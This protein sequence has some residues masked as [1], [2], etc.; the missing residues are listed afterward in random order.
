RS[1]QRHPRFPC[2]RTAVLGRRTTFSHPSSAA[3]GSNSSPTL[4]DSF[5]ADVD[6]IK[7]GTMTSRRAFV[8]CTCFVVA[9]A[10]VVLGHLTLVAQGSETWV[11]TWKLNV[12]KSKYSPGPGPK[13]GTIKISA[14][15]GGWAAVSDA[16]G[17]DGKPTHLEVN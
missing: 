10:V 8:A 17:A 7:E 9:G 15:Q 3:L 5:A 12:A 4:F 16:I 13:S 2:R 11:G 1:I 14:P 6:R